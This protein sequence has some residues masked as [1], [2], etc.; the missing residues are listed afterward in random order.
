VSRTGAAYTVCIE[1]EKPCRVELV[2]A[3]KALSVEGASF[4]QK[5]DSIVLSCEG[6]SGEIKV[7]V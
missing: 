7:T 4:E 3:G 1:A 6:V 5:D 2:H